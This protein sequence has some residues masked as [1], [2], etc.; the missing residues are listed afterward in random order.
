MPRSIVSVPDEEKKIDPS[1]F[2]IKSGL[3]IKIA[4]GN[5]RMFFTP[6]KFTSL[7]D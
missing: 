4:L 5:F 6:G 7:S 3:D 1:A 2:D